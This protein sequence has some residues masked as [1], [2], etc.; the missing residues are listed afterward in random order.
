MLISE[1]IEQIFKEIGEATMDD[2]AVHLQARGI[3]IP[4]KGIS[5]HLAHLTSSGRLKKVSSGR[6]GYTRWSKP[7][8]KK[9]VCG[10]FE[11]KPHWIV[12]TPLSS[13]QRIHGG[14]YAR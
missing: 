13:L 6:K 1:Q 8:V 2:V 3:D 4:R 9:V 14:F 12:N 11:E 10:A 7:G 5:G